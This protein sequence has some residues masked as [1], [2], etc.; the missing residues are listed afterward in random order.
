MVSLRILSGS[1]AG[2]TLGPLKLPF[3]V[4]RSSGDQVR[5][6][7]DGVWDGHL[8][9]EHGDGDRIVASRNGAAI[10]GRNGEPLTA[11]VA[12][13]NGDCFTLGSAAIEI[14]LSAPEVKPLWRHEWPLWLM[15]AAAVVAQVWMVIVH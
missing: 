14:W 11:S 6:G 5:L 15:V 12:I 3:S 8:L 7:D 9:L 13:G 1:R 10:V 2:E 4:G